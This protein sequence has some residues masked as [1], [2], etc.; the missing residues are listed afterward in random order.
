MY[1]DVK[2]CNCLI[3]E[4]NG[5]FPTGVGSYVP[6]ALCKSPFIKWYLKNTYGIQQTNCGRHDNDEDDIIDILWMN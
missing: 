4:W 6:C 3:V 1:S 5:S 2:G